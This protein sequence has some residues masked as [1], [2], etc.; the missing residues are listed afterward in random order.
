MNLILWQF[1]D[2]K[3]PCFAVSDPECKGILFHFTYPFVFYKITYE[4]AVHLLSFFV[5][6]LLIFLL[7]NVNLKAAKRGNLQS[8]LREI[9]LK[10]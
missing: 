9:L 1:Q 2:T 8:K 4:F 10:Q 7:P 3:G 5:E 6:K